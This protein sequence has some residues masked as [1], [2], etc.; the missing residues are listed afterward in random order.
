MLSVS[1]TDVSSKV[2]PPQL[3][4]PRHQEEE[5]L[6]SGVH[7]LGAVRD[8]FTGHKGFSAPARRS[9]RLN[10]AACF[11]VSLLALALAIVLAR[12][13][14]PGPIVAIVGIGGVVFFGFSILIALVRAMRGV[15]DLVHPIPERTPVGTRNAIG[16]ILGNFLMAGLGMYVAYFTTA[17]FSRGRQ[18]RRYGRVLLPGLRSSSAWTTSTVVVDG[19]EGLPPGVADQWRENGRTE[20]ASVAAF[21]R[22][23][24]DLM[25]LG[26]PPN[27]IA[28]A[29]EDA[30]DEIRHTELCFS[31]ACALDGTSVSPGPFPEAQR[32]TTLPRSRKLALA[33]LALDSL[34]DGA[35]HEGVSARIIAKLA[36]RC[37]VPAIFA[38]LKE[39]AADEGRHSA[40][41]WAV[42]E[43]CLDEGG[44]P[45]GEALLGAIHAL[46]KQMNSHLPKAAAEGR[47]ERWGIHG[48]VL[49]AVEYDA[50]L[51]SVIRRV[52]AMVAAPS[53]EA[54]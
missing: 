44:R 46:P 33:K 43:W 32:V 31:L 52:Q 2:H 25:A 38:A 17:G 3:P 21:A 48:H 18:L 41:G 15:V 30:L 4:E 53:T 35:L 36:R 10:T 20:H 45:V 11:G 8:D 37:E 23:T 34:V 19:L 28:A 54:A 27:L 9:L 42:V 40:H 13:A 14:L 29:N 22:L 5:Q 50:A 6:E 7:P 12:L 24:L 51:A 49:E 47:W 26:A 39:I 1:S 16:A